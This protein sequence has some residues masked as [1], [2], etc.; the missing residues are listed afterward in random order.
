M[1]LRPDLVRRKLLSIEQ[2]VSRPRSWQPITE[3]RLAQ[4]LLLQWAVERGL[5][6]ASEALF[7]TG[8]H[9]LAGEFAETVDRDAAVP[10]RLVARGVI[11]APTGSRLR[12]WAGFRNV[13]VHD[14]AEVDLA[15]VAA[16]CA[17]L[18]DFDAFVRD[19]ELWLASRE[20]P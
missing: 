9:V 4:D 5:Q 8:N 13:L 12:G 17:R 19:V 16:G 6:V 20:G 2:A 7:D 3:E 14:Y 15:R 18:D 10:E 1:P 11:T